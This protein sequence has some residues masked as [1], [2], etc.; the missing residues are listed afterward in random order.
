MK[1]VKVEMI[2]KQA[3]YATQRTQCASVAKRNKLILFSVVVT[4]YWESY[5]KRIYP[6]KEM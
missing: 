2:K 1:N 4:V 6:V 5:R 3:V